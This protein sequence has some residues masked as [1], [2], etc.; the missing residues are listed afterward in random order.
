MPAR[1]PS[2]FVAILVSLVACA[3]TPVEAAVLTSTSFENED[4]TTNNGFYFD[5]GDSLVDHDLIN[6]AGESPVDSTALTELTYDASYRNT[7]SSVGLTD[8]DA[9]GVTNAISTV[10]AFTDG[11]QGYQMSDP[12]GLMSLSFADVNIASMGSVMISIDSF[13][14]ST[15]W[16]TTDSYRVF[17]TVDGSEIDLLSTAGSDIDDLGIEGSWM[18]LST[19][20]TGNLASLTVELD[21]NSADESIFVDNVVFETVSAIPEPGALPI[22]LIALAAIHHRN[23]RRS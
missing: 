2:S 8:G 13:V 7:R 20:V 17:A 5:L 11:T 14:N 1:D 18:P 3:A 4:L 9:V 21:S 12:D 19:V 23:R 22:S 15:T 6:N 16:E 10:G